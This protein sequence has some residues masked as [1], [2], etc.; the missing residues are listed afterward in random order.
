MSVRSRRFKKLAVDLTLLLGSLT[1][2]AVGLEVVLRLVMPK[3]EPGTTWGV[4]VSRNSDGFR[5]REFDKPKPPETH[6]VVVLGDSF[7]WGV[8]LPLEGALPKLL[9][10]R[11][12][13]E[14][15]LGSIEVINAAIPGH[16]TVQ[17]ALLLEERG[18]AYEPDVVLIIYNLNDIEYLPH[19]DPGEPQSESAVEVVELDR[20]EDIEQYSRHAGFRGFV[21][22]LERRSVLVRFLV[23]R[24]GRVLRQA[25]WIDSPEFSW[26]EKIFAGFT[27]ANPGW[28][29]SQ[30]GLAEIV[31][32]A[33]S[34]DAEVIVAI[35][36]LFANLRNYQGRVAHA[37]VRDY[38]L[39]LGVEVVDLLPLFEGTPTQSHWINFLDS[40]PNAAAHRKVAESLVP[41]LVSYL[42]PLSIAGP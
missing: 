4:A 9:Q 17:E 27:D 19:L 3:Q 22:A 36:P 26:V 25:G 28:R 21:L 37:A 5:D 40:H 39:T 8:G 23:P 30:R 41:V 6:R 20:G 31:S 16:N 15:G 32:F 1:L 34:A 29:E 10:A 11:L 42:R 38:C 18:L 2:V 7:V 12:R 14:P 35:Y 33:E 24:V 13:T